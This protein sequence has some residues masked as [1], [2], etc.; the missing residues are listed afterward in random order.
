MKNNALLK[1]VRSQKNGKTYEN[2]VIELE[3]ITFQVRYAFYN[4]KLAYKVAKTLEG[5]NDDKQ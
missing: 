1:I 3:G 5:L 4:R 2:L